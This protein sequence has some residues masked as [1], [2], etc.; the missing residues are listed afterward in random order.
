[1]LSIRSRLSEI[2]VAMSANDVSPSLAAQYAEVPFPAWPQPRWTTQA[3]SSTLPRLW[4]THPEAV[5]AAAVVAWL[6]GVPALVAA[7]TALTLFAL[8]FFVLLA[9]LIAAGFTWGAWRC[10]RRR[11][12]WAARG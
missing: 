5:R 7:A 2:G 10:D 9:P 4:R 8:T 6:V 12:A 11:P 1:M 3:V